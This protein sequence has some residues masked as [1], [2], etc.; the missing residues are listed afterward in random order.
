MEYDSDLPHMLKVFKYF[1]K[2]VYNV[3][4]EYMY[5]MKMKIVDSKPTEIF[6]VSIREE[7]G[8][9]SMEIETT[10]E[11]IIEMLRNLPP[12]EK[13][14]LIEEI[15]SELFREI[16]LEEISKV[17]NRIYQR[18]EKIFREVEN[19][20]RQLENCEKAVLEELDSDII[21]RITRILLKKLGDEKYWKVS[22]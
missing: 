21:P 10:D 11:K 12:E 8:K 2:H 16:Q 4:R 18:I 7:D 22:R 20:F 5:F 15:K 19:M 3:E 6:K 14:R 17:T 1:L 13:S 9:R